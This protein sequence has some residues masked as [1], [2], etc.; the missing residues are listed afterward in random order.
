V[1]I[2]KPSKVNFEGFCVSYRVE[3]RPRSFIYCAAGVAELLELAAGA[4]APSVEAYR[5]RFTARARA[6]SAS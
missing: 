5:A 2:K 3:W 6:S 4:D 1:N